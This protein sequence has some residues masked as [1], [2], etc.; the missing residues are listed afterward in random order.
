[1][2]V[3]VYDSLEVKLQRFKNTLTEVEAIRLQQLRSEDKTGQI[4]L[5]YRS[6]EFAVERA[7]S[8]P[9]LTREEKEAVHRSLWAKLTV[10]EASLTPEELALLLTQLSTSPARAQSSFGVSEHVAG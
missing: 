1:M 6:V 8:A 7:V 3:S 10:F 5:G 9:Q 4:V 2:N